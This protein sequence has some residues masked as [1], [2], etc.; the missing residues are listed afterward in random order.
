M[1]RTMLIRGV[2][3][4]INTVIVLLLL[5]LLLLLLVLLLL[6]LVLLLQVDAT[7]PIEG[8]ADLLQLALNCSSTT[9]AATAV[10]HMPATAASAAS[11]MPALL[12]PVVA[13]RLL[14]TAATRHHAAAV[15]HMASTTKVEYMQQHIDAATLEAMLVRLL[16]HYS[17]LRLLTRLPAATHLSIEAGMRLMQAAKHHGDIPPALYGLPGAQQLRVAEMQRLVFEMQHVAVEEQQPLAALQRIHQR[18]NELLARLAAITPGA[19]NA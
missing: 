17:C 18:H 9:A 1:L 10:G 11:L 14:I 6:V 16:E 4:I 15:T 3:M 12:E 2:L 7:L 5:L 19:G 8:A 13:R